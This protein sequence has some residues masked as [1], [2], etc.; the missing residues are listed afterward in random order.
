MKTIEFWIHEGDSFTGNIEF[1]DGKEWRKA[2]KLVKE[3]KKGMH[4]DVVTVER[5]VAY[6]SEDYL[7]GDSLIDR[8]YE[9]LY[10]REEQ[11]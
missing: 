1:L 9:S 6:W 5:V 11:I 7:E 3:C 8:E 4:P 10:E 2:H